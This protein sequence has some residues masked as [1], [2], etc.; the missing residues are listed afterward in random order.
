VREPYSHE[1]A[2]E[3]EH[4]N[5]FEKMRSEEGSDPALGMEQETEDMKSVRLRNKARIGS[6]EPAMN[7]MIGRNKMIRVFRVH[8]RPNS[9]SALICEIS[10]LPVLLVVQRSSVES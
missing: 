4:E 7:F 8:S 6:T 1:A 5:C 2:G 3:I 9:R 10:G